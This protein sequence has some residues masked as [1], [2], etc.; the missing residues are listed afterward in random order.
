[1]ADGKSCRPTVVTSLLSVNQ[2]DRAALTS[3][4]QLFF[5]ALS[6]SDLRFQSAIRFRRVFL[7]KSHR[8]RRR[9]L[10]VRFPH[11]SA[12]PRLAIV[13]PSS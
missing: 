5:L 1:V 12:A 11:A 9:W 10:S 3:D 2:A 6:D 7:S 13:D 4:C 8:A